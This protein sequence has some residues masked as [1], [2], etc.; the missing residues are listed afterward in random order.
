[1]HRSINIRVPSQTTPTRHELCSSSSSCTPVVLKP[2]T[3]YRLPI[4]LPAK[5]A[6]KRTKY[7][8]QAGRMKTVVGVLLLVA[9]AWPAAFLCL[10]RTFDLIAV[11]VLYTYEPVEDFL[12]F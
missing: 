11:S 7:A 12:V 3:V 4:R 9:A 10:A 2:V 5:S 6:K 1:M 8:E